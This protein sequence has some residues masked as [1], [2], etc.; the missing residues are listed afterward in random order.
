MTT[1]GEHIMAIG[2]TT[3]EMPSYEDL[4]TIKEIE[5]SLTKTHK[6]DIWSPFLRAIKDFKLIEAGDTVAIAIS[7]G[8]D[9]LLLAKLIQMLHRHTEVPFTPVYLSMDPGFHQVNREALLRNCA[10][11]E[12][13]V[14]LFDSDIFEVV[15]R[16]SEDYPCYMCARMRRG[17][18]Y[19][20]AQELGAN[21]LA[22]G[23][24][25]DDAIET[26]LLNLFYTGCFK[27]MVPKLH[28]SNFEGLELIRPLYYV[29][30]E[31]IKRFIAKS[32][33]P[34]MNCGCIVAAGKTSSKRKEIKDLIATLKETNPLIDKCIFNA[35]SNINLDAILGYQEGDKK[36]DF[37]ELYAKRS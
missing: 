19:A 7:G 23:H 1:Q 32:G 9:S 5:R 13:P 31:S 28:S 16:I 20:K 18:L 25:F 10:H 6:K 24:H 21:K 14:Q 15:G 17:F 35:A 12:I 36:F 34:A 37:N 33:V 4:K 27:T 26:T 29:R 3:V 8:K 11:L 30:E 22:L 2:C